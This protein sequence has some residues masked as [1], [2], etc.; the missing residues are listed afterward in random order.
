MCDV[1]RM[2]E[3]REVVF[4]VD[5]VLKLRLGALAVEHFHLALKVQGS[6]ENEATFNNRL[7]I[8]KRH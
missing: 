6:G 3:G 8:T 5:A 2:G 4:I 1:M 7:C